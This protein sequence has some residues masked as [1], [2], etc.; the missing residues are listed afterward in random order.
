LTDIYDRATEREEELR[1]DALDQ[2]ARRAGL[3][4]KTVTDSA[5]ECA[6]CDDAIPQNRRLALPGVQTCVACQN[7]LERATGRTKA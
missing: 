5:T 4:G 6:I 1:Q 3:T 2:Q 7:E